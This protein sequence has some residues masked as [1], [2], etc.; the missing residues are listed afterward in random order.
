MTG[1]IFNIQKFSLSDGPGIRTSVFLKGCPLNCVWCHNPES[2]SFSN[3]I[4]YEDAKCIGCRKCAAVCGHNCHIF[5]NGHIF[6]RSECTGCLDCCSNCVTGA[7]KCVGTDITSDEVITEVLKDRVFYRNSGGGITLTGGEPMA[8]FEFTRELLA[9]AKE[10]GLHSCI[11]TCGYAHWEHFKSII[12]LVDIF[13]FDFKE[14]DP[15]KHKE[16]TGVSNELIIDNLMALDSSGAKIALRCPV[17]PG[18]ND[19]DEHFNGIANISNNLK[20]IIEVD[21]EPYNPLGIS[22]LKTLGK[23][24]FS[25]ISVPKKETVDRWLQLISA[26]CR[27]PVK[28]L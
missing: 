28:K 13:L 7:L 25:K 1:K 6:D 21:I 15:K 2:K 4:T 22:K 18:F 20:N 26:N 5:D 16:F 3:E 17:I 24:D 10:N 14:T 12:P 27:K 11:E 9:K 23:T 8:Q 19:T